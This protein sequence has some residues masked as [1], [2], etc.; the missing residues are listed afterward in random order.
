MVYVGI[1]RI[2]IV[3]DMLFG[4]SL[5]I[6]ENSDNQQI[7]NAMVLEQGDRNG[8]KPSVGTIVD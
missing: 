1:S 3:T 7:S 4:M 8:M 2:S 5:L 6:M